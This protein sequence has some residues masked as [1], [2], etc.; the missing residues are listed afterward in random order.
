MVF[1]GGVIPPPT[2]LPDWG[3][4][5]APFG[6]NGDEMREVKVEDNMSIYL[7]RAKAGSQFPAHWHSNVEMFIL[8]KGSMTMHFEERESRLMWPGDGVY[9]P[10]EEMHSCI[11]HEDSFII[12]AYTPSFDKGKWESI[13]NITKN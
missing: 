12:L 9:I 1:S 8:I 10:K 13:Q 4:D 5:W 7:Y 6:D 11:F 3:E 2:D